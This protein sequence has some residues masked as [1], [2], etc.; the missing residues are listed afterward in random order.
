MTKFRLAFCNLPTRFHLFLSQNV[1]ENSSISTIT[2]PSLDFDGDAREI[3]FALN[4]LLYITHCASKP[5]EQI[6]SLFWN[7]HVSAA[8]QQ[9]VCVYVSILAW[10]NNKQKN[11]YLYRPLKMVRHTMLSR[12]RTSVITVI[13]PLNRPSTSSYIRNCEKDDLDF[14]KTRLNREHCVHCSLVLLRWPLSRFVQ[15]KRGRERSRGNIFMRSH[16][17]CGDRLPKTHTYCIWERTSRQRNSRDA[18][19][20][21]LLSQTAASERWKK[22]W[23]FMG[24]KPSLFKM[25]VAWSARSTWENKFGWLLAF[26]S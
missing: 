8:R 5:G 22:N 25:N 16:A 20:C 10:I 17:I 15:V 12:L 3:S 2:L 18:Y 11:I 1:R 21:L 13:E 9:F 19:I 14:R 23:K 26:R 24:S 7:R 6:R 4:Y